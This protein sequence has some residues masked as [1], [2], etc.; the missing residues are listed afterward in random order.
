MGFRVGIPAIPEPP[1]PSGSR[2]TLDQQVRML[3]INLHRNP[4]EMKRPNRSGSSENS[5]VAD[6]TAIYH[7]MLYISDAKHNNKPL[8]GYRWRMLQAW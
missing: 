4:Q 5:K 3:G 1:Q 8:I 7:I 2:G 6:H